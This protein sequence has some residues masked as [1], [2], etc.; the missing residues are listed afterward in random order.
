MLVTVLV[1]AETVSTETIL[2]LEQMFDGGSLQ[3][4]G[5]HT[6]AS[7]SLCDELEEDS[8]D[9]LFSTPRDRASSMTEKLVEDQ[10]PPWEI[11][12]LYI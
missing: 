7:M 5:A 12:H 11:M 4:P 8:G 10:K 2:Q 9:L 1:G 3:S 6:S